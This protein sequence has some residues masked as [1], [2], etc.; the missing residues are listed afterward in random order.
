MGRFN[1][2][3]IWEIV[4]LFGVA[5]FA[6]TTVMVLFLLA[7]VGITQSLGPM[8]ILELIPFVLPQSLQYSIPP[9]VLFAVCSVFGRI[10]ADNEILAVT[11]AGVPPMTVIKPVL[12]CA[13]LLSVCSVWMND[14]AVSWGTP[15]INR[16]I[17]RS[18]EQIVYGVLRSERSYTG[19]GGFVIHVQGIGDDGR[20]LLLPMI[21]LPQA[22]GPP[23]E[24]HARS[25]RI[26]MKPEEEVLA[27]ELRDSD[28]RANGVVARRNGPTS[29]EIQLAEAARKGT[30]GGSV[31]DYAMRRI[32]REVNLQEQNITR[33]EEELAARTAMGLSAGRFAW[34]DDH[35]SDASI[36]TIRVGSHR[37]IRLH[38]EPWRRWA[39]GFSCFCFVWLGVPMA[40]WMRSADHW[41]SFAVCFLP[42]LLLFFPVFAVGLNL[43]K[44]GASPPISVWGG[45]VVLLL[46]GAWWLRK[47]SRG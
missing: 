18:I 37:L 35:K 24:I 16:V 8:A 4:K 17:M 11:S 3:V 25:A 7:K 32:N 13:L 43:A 10:S 40:I 19:S 21:T 5:L 44:S 38:V 22:S 6:F 29:I 23:L 45:N 42:I 12:I 36:D 47:I 2:Y 46:S 30:A 26:V 15:G 20:E 1:R 33:A 9:T 28:F 39:F 14:L 31:A 34:L 41:T 27:I